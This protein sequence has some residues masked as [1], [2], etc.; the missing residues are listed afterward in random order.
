MP[1][2]L[3]TT[4]A[5]GTGAY[6]YP[7]TDFGFRRYD[8][9]NKQDVGDRPSRMIRWEVR[10]SWPRNRGLCGVDPSGVSYGHVLDNSARWDDSLWHSSH[11]HAP[12]R[13]TGTVKNSGG[14]PLAGAKLRL[15]KTNGHTAS[16]V[17][18]PGDPIDAAV[19]RTE[20]AG[21]GDGITVG[22]YAFGVLDNTTQH[23][24]VA[25]SSDGTLVGT[26]VKTLVGS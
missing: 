11:G 26:T 5:P 2:Y 22:S 21:S 7:G 19:A 24:I 13:I 3:H 17:T 6:R 14:T 15:Y 25:E 8:R 12:Y 20:S 4:G 9:K 23:Y 1:A 16:D 18:T 10:R